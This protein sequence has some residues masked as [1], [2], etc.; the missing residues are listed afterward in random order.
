MLADDLTAFNEAG[1]SINLGL[2]DDDGRPMALRAFG[3]AVLRVEPLRIRVLVPGRPLAAI[4]RGPASTGFPIAVTSSA[5][6]LFRSI[7]LKGTVAELRLATEEEVAAAQ[8]LFDQVVA[9]LARIEGHPP[10]AVAR[11]FPADLLACT[12]EV[13]EA[14]DQTPGP[15]AGRAIGAGGGER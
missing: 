6:V 3:L 5:I 2:A 11:M 9:V 10:E 8:V 13:R 14:F 15:G 1:A 4:R 7:Q 12:V